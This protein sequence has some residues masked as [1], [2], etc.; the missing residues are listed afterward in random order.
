MTARIRRVR[1]RHTNSGYGGCRS[2]SFLKSVTTSAVFCSF[3]LLHHHLT[4][5]QP[6]RI[7]PTCYTEVEYL[8]IWRIQVCR[9]T[10]SHYIAGTLK[11]HTSH[12]KRSLTITWTRHNRALRMARSKPPPARP[13]FSLFVRYT[14]KTQSSSISPREVSA[15]EHLLR[16]GKR[17]IEMY[18]DPQVRDIWVS[19]AMRDWETSYKEER[20]TA[21]A[22]EP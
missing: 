20:H 21:T 7:P 16:K 8:E 17:Q 5:T 13:K 2:T 4:D 12:T 15:I 14:F 6:K 9:K 19:Q 11:D 22:K 1:R 3:I 18:E 10:C